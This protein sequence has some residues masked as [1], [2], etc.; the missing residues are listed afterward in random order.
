M[1]DKTMACKIGNVKV[2]ELSYRVIVGANHVEDAFVLYGAM[3]G[4]AEEEEGHRRAFLGVLAESMYPVPEEEF[5]GLVKESLEDNLG[6]VEGVFW[7]LL[8]RQVRGMKQGSFERFVGGR[9]FEVLAQRWE[10]VVENE[11]VFEVVSVVIAIQERAREMK[12][13]MVVNG[14]I[15]ALLPFLMTHIRESVQ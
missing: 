12:M 11:E 14:K 4:R 13:E 7:K 1:R 10:V 6:R 9:F 5:E 3:R 15:G 2:Y 8:N